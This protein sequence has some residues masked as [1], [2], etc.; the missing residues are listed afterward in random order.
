[1][2]TAKKV[3][4]QNYHIVWIERD[5]FGKPFK[6]LGRK[7]YPEFSSKISPVISLHDWFTLGALVADKNSAVELHS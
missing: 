1:M 7:I 5:L 2:S 6:V 4:L 3:L